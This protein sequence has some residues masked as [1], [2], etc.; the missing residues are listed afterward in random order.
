MAESHDVVIIGAG[1]AGLAAARQ[2]SIHGIDVVVID[3]SDA[4]GGRVRSDVVDDF[5]LDRGFQ[6]YNPSYPEAAR[7]L[8]HQ[9]LHLQALVP[10]V[11]VS[12]GKHRIHLGD[13]R[14][15]PGWALQGVSPRSGSALSK[16]RFAKYAWKQSRRPVADI[17]REA[18]RDSFSALRAA[19]IDPTFIESVLRPFLTGVFLES[20]LSTSQRFLDLVLRSFIR[21]VPSVPAAGMQAIPVQLANSLPAGSVRLSMRATQVT[22]TRVRTDGD[23]FESRAVIVATDPV[24]AATLIPGLTIPAGNAVTTWYHSTRATLTDGDGVLVVDGERRGPV[25]N[26]VAISNAAPDYAP[27]GRTLVSTSTL[28]TDTSPRAETAVREHLA[29]LHGTGTR[30]WDLI[31]VYAIPYALPAMLPPL[32]TR[33]PVSLGDGL[34]VAGD[35]RD[36]ASIQGAMVSG[37]RSADAVLASL[38]VTSI[39]GAA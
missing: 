7:V 13:P 36:T 28:G 12:T 8:D 22:G 3:S 31:G 37:R 18:D 19:G 39:T 21:G 6:L 5:I 38:G 17:E 35:H 10:G 1:L 11:V 30:D 26:S 23:D 14:R 32:Q 33:Q 2:L 27:A 20:E 24:S 34:F 4:V 29:L 16:M 25:I 15:K 9:A